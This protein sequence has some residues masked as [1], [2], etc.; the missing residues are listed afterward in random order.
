MN[1]SP[2]L[3]ENARGPFYVTDECIGCGLCV[4]YAPDS[5][6]WDAAGTRCFVA[7]QPRGVREVSAVWDA[8]VDCP[9]AALR[10]DGEDAP[11][12]PGGRACSR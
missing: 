9:V 2:R 8:V 1:P 6:A 3:A 5:L 10:H 7:R 12:P 4:A 11:T